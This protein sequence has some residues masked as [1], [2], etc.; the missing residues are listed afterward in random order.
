MESLR[1][2]P[3]APT[4]RRTLIFRKYSHSEF[5]S[6]HFL[7]RKKLKRSSLQS[8]DCQ[9]NRSILKKDYAPSSINQESF[10]QNIWRVTNVA[11]THL[12]VMNAIY[13]FILFAQPAAKWLM[14]MFVTEKIGYMINNIKDAM[15]VEN[16]KVVH[17]IV[18]NVLWECARPVLV[19]LYEWLWY[20][21]SWIIW[22]TKECKR[23]IQNHF[24]LLLP[25]RNLGITLILC[26]GGGIIT[27]KGGP[28]MRPLL[29]HIPWGQVVPPQS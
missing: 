5:R 25:P 9:F 19:L 2:T 3:N 10:Q 22:K 7:L 16:T 29:A 6:R 28:G 23:L 11:N 12:A 15:S 21:Y 14:K 20:I 24:L 27:G 4:A 13:A 18:E 26:A 17:R 8:D 1:R